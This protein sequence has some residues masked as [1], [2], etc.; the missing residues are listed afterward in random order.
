MEL[1]HHK[2]QIYNNQQNT[3]LQ[4]KNKKRHFARLHSNASEQSE[5]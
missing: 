4:D 1:T 3:I 2:Q 5:K